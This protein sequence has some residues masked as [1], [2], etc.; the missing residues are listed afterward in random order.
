MAGN[1][2]EWT[3]DRYDSKYYAD[4]PRAN[5]TGPAKGELRVVRGG[6]F[7]NYASYV[8]CAFRNYSDPAYRG[9]TFGFRVVV[10]PGL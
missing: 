9:D 4:S 6:A 3:A 2:W 7:G 1:V 8:R 10:S 5:P